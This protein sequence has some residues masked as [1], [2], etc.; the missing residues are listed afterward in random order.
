VEIGFNSNNLR[1]ES[2]P[3]D[4]GI[5]IVKVED[6]PV[7]EK[8]SFTFFAKNSPTFHGLTLDG[9]YGVAV[10]NI[11]MR[12]RPWPGFRLADHK[13]LKSMASELNIGLFILQFG[14]NVLPTRTDDYRF[15]YIHFVK[16]LQVLKTLFP[17]I[18]VLIIGVQ[19][20]AELI[21]NKVKPVRRA[22][23]IAD[24]Q[25]SAALDCGMGFLDLQKAMGGIDA[26]VTW[27][28]QEPP[29]ISSD[30]MHF[31]RKGAYEV[32]L[33]IWNLMEAL[34]TRIEESN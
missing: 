10:D 11:A 16:E 15:Y 19:S 27:A 32:G 24:A 20:S 29:F 12:G 31:T 23:L 5:Q 8:V 9:E 33:K 22:R 1:S 6:I 7:G 14:T 18:P 17:D 30:Y 26:A 13:L 21:D 28:K 25:R 34:R 4:E 2:V 3:A